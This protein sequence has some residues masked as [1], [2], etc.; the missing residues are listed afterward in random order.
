M[1]YKGDTVRF[2]VEFMDYS[3]IPLDPSDIKFNAYDE[4]DLL[5]ETVPVPSGNRT[6]VGKYFMEFTIP[7]SLEGNSMIFEFKGMYRDKP[8]LSR[9]SLPVEF[10]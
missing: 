5:L 10:V 7:Q 9:D 2:E 6:D 3:N 8:V 4:N 1:A